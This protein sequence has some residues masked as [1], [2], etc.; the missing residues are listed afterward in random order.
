MTAISTCPD[1]HELL[2]VALGEPAGEAIEAHLAGC[3]AC[4]ERVERLRA[5]LTALRSDLGD[6]ATPASTEPDPAVNHT[7]EPAGG[8]TTLPWVVHPAEDVDPE[9]IGPE[10]VAA[11][12]ART[13]GQSER[14]GAIGK[15]LVVDQID[16]GTQGQVFRVI[17]PKLGKDMLLKLGRQPVG[18]DERTS[19]V[20]EGRLLV[21][22]EHI[23]LVRIFDLDFHNDLPFLVMEYVHGRNLE[24]FAREEPVPPGRAAVLVAKLAGALA[25]VHRRGI[26]HRDIKPRNIL[27][28]EAGEPRLIDFGLARLRHAWSDRDDP[29]WGGTLAYM[30]P[31]QARWDHE[32]LGPRSDI[33]AL[34]GVLY[35]LLTGREPFVGQDQDAVWDRA[36]R[37]DF[38]AG[39][40]RAAKVPR[41]LERIC[42]K[43]MAAR[44]ADRYATAEEFGRA[45]QGSLAWPKVRAAVGV[46]GAVVL[47]GGG[48]YF[49]ITRTSPPPS[50]T[51][52]SMTPTSSTPI[53]STPPPSTPPVPSLAGLDTVRPAIVTPAEPLKGRIDLLVVKSKDGTRR[54]LRL[55]DTRAVPVKAED[56]FR[57]EARLHRPAYLY[58]F[59]I[60][61]DGNVAPLYPWKDHVWSQRP[62]QEHKVTRTELPELFNEVLEIP[63]SPPGLETL[64]LLAREDSPLPREDEPKLAQGL[65]AKVTVPPATSMDRAIW[66]EDGEEV[67]FEPPATAGPNHR[68]ED[69]LTRGIPSTRRRKSDDPVLQIRALMS[70]K[71]KPLGSYSQAVIFPNQGGP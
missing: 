31:E 4:R 23:N 13:E 69:I 28:D 36:R 16:G 15:Y 57:I 46:I 19:L 35:H 38:D 44:P 2:P 21:D 6:V 20:A 7:A 22:L 10:A 50:S 65:A 9:P 25:M 34:G 51:P 1:E 30:A 60:S 54:R 11:A 48:L 66:I 71:V 61:S 8:G 63:S 26:I 67:T 41:R 59:W 64:V 58:L 45:L 43:A 68:G 24:Q 47:L 55:A 70:A 3:P 14:P 18:D 5:E 40:L 17:H 42:L 12:R 27:I 53:S 39:A 29:T 49:F 56:Q 32:A 33:F 62:K 37:C 52:T